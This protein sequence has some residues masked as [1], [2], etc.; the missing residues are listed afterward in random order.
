M[1]LTDEQVADDTSREVSNFTIGFLRFAT[2]KLGANAESAGSGTLVKVGSI[3]GVLTAAHVISELTRHSSVGIVVFGGEGKLQKQ[4]IDMKETEA[5][6]F[7]KPENKERGPD[8]AFLRLPEV[9]AS[10]LRATHLFLDLEELR[11][12]SDSDP[13]FLDWMVGVVGEWTTELEP[14]T[15]PGGLT[16]PLRRKRFQA[17]LGVGKS[18]GHRTEN[19]F[20]LFDFAPNVPRPPSTYGGVSGGA[21]WHLYIEQLGENDYAVRGKRFIGVPFYELYDDKNALYLVCHGPQS[22]G[23]LSDAI[24]SKWAS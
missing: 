16:S 17:L 5:V 21:I 14:I 20:D 2:D 7:Y 6:I 3:F 13:P 12:R 4:E 10:N 18:V 15:P 9:N 24:L 19:G 22:Y 11:A 1:G 8:I 23:Q